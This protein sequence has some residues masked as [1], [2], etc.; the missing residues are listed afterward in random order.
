MEEIKKQE[1]LLIEAETKYEEAR[2]TIDSLREETI[3]FE[4]SDDYEAYLALSEEEKQEKYPKEYEA[5]KKIEDIRKQNEE[6]SDKKEI[7]AQDL[8]KHVNDK[9]KEDKKA[10]DKANS[11]YDAIKDEI[12][13]IEQEISELKSS[14]E[15]EKGDVAA[16]DT[17]EKLEADLAKKK[18]ELIN[19]TNNIEK[20]TNQIEELKAKKEKLEEEYELS[21][22]QNSIEEE[23][24]EAT[25]PQ[26][27][28]TDKIRQKLDANKSTL[29]TVRKEIN[30]LKKQIAVLKASDEYKNK[31]KATI[32]KVEGLEEEL[33]NKLAARDKIQARIKEYEEQIKKIEQVD[34]PEKPE[35]AVPEEMVVEAEEQQ[36][37]EQN[38]EV[39]EE[40]K[41][42]K[43][44]RTNANRTNAPTTYVYANNNPE[45]EAKPVD[46]KKKLEE[47]FSK[48]YAKSKNGD[49]TEAEFDR[50]AEIL[51]NP[52]NYDKLNITTGILFNKAKVL[53]KAMAKSAKASEYTIKSD[54]SVLDEKIKKA[55][56]IVSQNREDLSEE[57]QIKW[58]NAQKELKQYEALKETKKVYNK[59]SRSRI[60]KKWSWLFVFEDTKKEALPEAVKPGGSLSEKLS[61]AVVSDAEYVEPKIVAPQEQ[62][63]EG[64]V[65]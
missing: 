9:M 12:S 51:K 3:D 26:T 34:E 2:K 41:E 16:I 22:T 10:L 30:Q 61:E 4:A 53:F 44:K 6:L 55:R 23:A 5:F 40:E 65:K 1:E 54:D 25:K 52:D 31:D 14:P 18:Q 24:V 46:E 27:T 17:L 63:K 13:K 43:K 56:E 42:P 48:L 19:I 15:Y 49:L 35:E 28:E 36:P 59:I 64:E 58:D 7:I 29:K 20:L 33:K 8:Y 39:A 50:L 62:T 38:A 57:E 45:E 21:E 47:E 60:E 11:V 37:D 32:E